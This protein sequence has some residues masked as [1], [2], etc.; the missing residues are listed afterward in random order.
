MSNE[1]EDSI[2]RGLEQSMAGQTVSLGSFAQY[3]SPLTDEQA[4]QVANQIAQTASNVY[5]V[6]EEILGRKLDSNETDA[7]YE[8]V[9]KVGKIFKCSECNIWRATSEV[10]DRD[11]CCV[12]CSEE[13]NEDDD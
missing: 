7:V 6:A 1:K 8:H 13:E 9:E 2:Q 5:R 3:T 11:D 4:D 12:E 10:G